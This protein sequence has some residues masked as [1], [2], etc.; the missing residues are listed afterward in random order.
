[1]LKA[2]IERILSLSE[3]HILTVNNEQYTD[4]ELTRV[5]R[6]LRAEPLEVHTL[7][8]L[9]TILRQAVMIMQSRRILT[10]ALLYIFRIII[11]SI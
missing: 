11:K 4:R 5:P 8:A 1:M 9:V 2:A 7:S 10:D 3:P 6:T